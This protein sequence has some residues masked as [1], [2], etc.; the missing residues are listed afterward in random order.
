M[1]NFDISRLLEGLENISE[2]RRQIRG[3]LF[4]FARD[5]YSSS[6]YWNA[7]LEHKMSF[8]HLSDYSDGGLL[9]I[10]KGIYNN[11]PKDLKLE[12]GGKS[13]EHKEPIF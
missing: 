6:K 12:C 9:G 13:I 4:K 8:N 11:L 1:D 10:C 3:K 7:G 2:Q 5:Y